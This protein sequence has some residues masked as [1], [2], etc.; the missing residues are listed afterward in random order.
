MTVVMLEMVEELKEI[1][2]PPRRHRRAVEQGQCFHHCRSFFHSLCQKWTA[3]SLSLF[4]SFLFTLFF[5][6]KD[7][8]S[9][10]CRWVPSAG[11]YQCLYASRVGG[12]MGFV[13]VSSSFPLPLALYVSSSLRC[14][15]PPLVH[16][17]FKRQKWFLC[18]L[19]AISVNI[20]QM[21]SLNRADKLW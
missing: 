17:V 19:A 14:L 1:D 11:R 4:F 13:K 10:S 15:H 7:P 12:W 5:A 20:F 21:K 18:D 8:L 9:S 3:L 16:H 2:R 6:A